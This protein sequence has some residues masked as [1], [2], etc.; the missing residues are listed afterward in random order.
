M[1]EI[2]KD[3]PDYEG[4][5]QVSNMGN[6]RSLDRYVKQHSGYKQFKK[7]KVLTLHLN[8]DGHLI[9]SLSINNTPKQIGIHRLLAMAFIPIPERLKDYNLDELIVHHKDFIPQNNDI[10]NL[11]WLTKKEHDKLHHESEETRRKISI[12]LK[13][14]VFSEERRRRMA[15][16]RRGCK[17]T[18]EHT[19]KQAAACSLPVEGYDMN[20]NV[21]ITFSSVREG[22]R[23]GFSHIS[24]CCRGKRK[25]DKGLYWRYVK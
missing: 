9:A 19:A 16:A 5:Y 15:D 7:G 11:I 8:S 25:R 22:K 24:A 12:A 3:I 6:V 4:L 2:W 21:V 14:R 20:G 23:N 1:E 10:D 17:H 18:P 13:G